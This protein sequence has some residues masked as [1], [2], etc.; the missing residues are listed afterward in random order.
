MAFGLYEN[1]TSGNTRKYFMRT[2]FLNYYQETVK[3]LLNY[4]SYISMEL[5]TKVQPQG[6][7]HNGYVCLTFMNF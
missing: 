5:P 6:S 4:H 3:L 1:K 7:N 2:K